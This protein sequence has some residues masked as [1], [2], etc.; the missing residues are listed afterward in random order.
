[1]SRSSLITNGFELTATTA[2]ICPILSRGVRLAY[3]AGAHAVSLADLD[4][5]FSDMDVVQVVFTSDHFSGGG[6]A[7]GSVTVDGKHIARVQ[8]QPPTELDASVGQLGHDC[9]T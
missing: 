7:N 4:F 8:D 6:N 2:P 3:H 5:D 1:M 9:C